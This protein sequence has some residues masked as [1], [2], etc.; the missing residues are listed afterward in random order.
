M[1]LMR[2]SE[3]QRYSLLNDSDVGSERKTELTYFYVFTVNELIIG[4][5]I[6]VN[7]KK[8]KIYYP[9]KISIIHPSPKITLHPVLLTHPRNS[10]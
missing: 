1:H 8:Q 6:K 3:G 2:G 10:V 9:I 7:L 5:K 4:N